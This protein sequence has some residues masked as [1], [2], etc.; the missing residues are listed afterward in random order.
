MNRTAGGA[1]VLTASEMVFILDGYVITNKTVGRERV[2]GAG[3]HGF[4]PW[5]RQTND[6]KNVHLLLSS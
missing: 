6:I 1:I 2:L 4:E 3:N 5:S